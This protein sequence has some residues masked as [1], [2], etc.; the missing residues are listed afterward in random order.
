[1]YNLASHLFNARLLHIVLAL[2]KR[3][4]L[5]IMMTARRV[6]LID[7]VSQGDIG[8]VQNLIKSGCNVDETDYC[9]GCAVIR[10]VERNDIKIL[11]VLIKANAKLNVL[12]PLGT[13]ALLLAQELKHHKIAQLIEVTLAQK[14]IPNPSLSV[15]QSNVKVGSFNGLRFYDNGSEKNYEEL[16]SRDHRNELKEPKN[17]SPIV[18]ARGS[19]N[20]K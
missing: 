19:K 6:P 15:T 4:E 20:T 17:T 2:F 13:S 1:V 11:K 16:K 8:E 10:C 9:G 5:T 14:K 12:D 3:L 18:P 7:F